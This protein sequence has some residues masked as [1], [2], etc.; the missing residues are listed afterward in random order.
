MKETSDPVLISV[1]VP[2]YG[3]EK[4]IERCARS[5]FEQT[6]Q[7]GIEYLF[8]DDCSPDRSIEILEK[9]LAEYP[10]RERQTTILRL[11]ENQGSAKARDMGM[12]IAE[13][14]YIAYCDSDDR[15]D[16]DAYRMIIEKALAEDLDMAIINDSVQQSNGKWILRF[17]DKAVTEIENSALDAQMRGLLGGGVVQKIIKRALYQ[18]H[19]LQ[20]PASNIGEDLVLSVQLCY[21]CQKIGCIGEKPLYYYYY[22]NES[23]SHK[24]TE[25]V[26]IKRSGDYK[27]N[28]DIVIGFL[29]EKGLYEK[30]K[31]R[32]SEFKLRCRNLLLPY[33]NERN[34]RLWRATYP[35][36]D[37][38]AYFS[39]LPKKELFKYLLV[40]S[41]MYRLF[42]TL[43]A[44]YWRIKYSHRKHI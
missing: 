23:Q 26:A 10:H 43:R 7:E 27:K 22:N 6:M 25:S 9:V 39:H 30:Y 35:E 3:V 38:W 12:A 8:V 16:R 18:N 41:R 32:L 37:R 33:M 13:G 15:V 28:I 40:R 20:L 1:I 21:Y 17:F 14:E 44:L 29:K 19:P 36:L 5:L 42:P 4:Y 24:P 31:H 34:Y 11:T 2:V